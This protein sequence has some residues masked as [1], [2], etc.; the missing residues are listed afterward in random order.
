Y[1]PHVYDRH[2]KALMIQRYGAEGLQEGIARSWMNSYVSRPGVKVRVDEMLKELHGVKEVTPE[3]VEK[4]AMD[5]AYGI[6]RS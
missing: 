4:Y 6:S 1:V 3:M 5:K 2:A